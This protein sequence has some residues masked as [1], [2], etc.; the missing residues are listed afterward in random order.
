MSRIIS[1]KAEK[2]NGYKSWSNERWKTIEDSVA[3]AQSV[4]IGEERKGDKVEDIST[5]S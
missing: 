2:N 5:T 4:I 1:N 3:I